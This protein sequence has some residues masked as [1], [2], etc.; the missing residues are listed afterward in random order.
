MIPKYPFTVIIEFQ[1]N[2]HRAPVSRSCE[3]LAGAM[4]VYNENVGRQDVRRVTVTCI[5]QMSEKHEQPN[6]QPSKK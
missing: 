6:R 1:T 3:T 4:A 5:L 2:R